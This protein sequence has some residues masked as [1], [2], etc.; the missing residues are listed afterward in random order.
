MLK[1]LP[2]SPGRNER[3]K[4][5]EISLKNFPLGQKWVKAIGEKITKNAG[6]GFFPL[7]CC[8]V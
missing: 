4:F 7:L 1:F 3:P 6:W 8:F 5:R 2:V